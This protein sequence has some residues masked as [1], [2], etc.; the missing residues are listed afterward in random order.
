[1]SI[2]NCE[3]LRYKISEEDQR[4]V[5]AHFCAYDIPESTT[6]TKILQ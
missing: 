2:L 1:M 6:E 4:E 5:W 3:E